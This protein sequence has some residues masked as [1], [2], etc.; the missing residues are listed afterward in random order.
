MG[1]NQTGAHDGKECRG[2]DPRRLLE[3]REGMDSVP[4]W[5]LNPRRKESPSP[6][7]ARRRRGQIQEWAHDQQDGGGPVG[8]LLIFL[9][10][11]R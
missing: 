11:W 8:W 5:R 7:Q 9:Y 2:E 1:E 10:D 4:E 3:G 6:Y